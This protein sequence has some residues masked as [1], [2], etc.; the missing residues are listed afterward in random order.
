[1][2]SDRH[3]TT[4]KAPARPLSYAGRM[5]SAPGFEPG[6]T[7]IKIRCL[8]SKAHAMTGILASQA[9]QLLAKRGVDQLRRQPGS[10]QSWNERM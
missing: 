1:M 3:D 10:C 4:Y 9:A 7:G 8:G 5:E 2:T 6:M